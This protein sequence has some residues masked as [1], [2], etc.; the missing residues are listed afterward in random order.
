M[1]QH[2]EDIQELLKRC[3]EKQITLNRKKMML[4]RQKV[5]F[6]GYMVGIEGIEL[7]PDKIQE[8]NQF[9]TPSAR[10]DIKTCPHKPI[11]AI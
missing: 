8:V 6:A 2:F 10:H 11:Q 9:P 3:K 1:E 5:K 7:D 4:V